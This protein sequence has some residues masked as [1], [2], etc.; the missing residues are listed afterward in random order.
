MLAPIERIH[1]GFVH[2]R[3]AR[4]LASQI[5]ALIEPH[6]SMLDIG[7]GDGVIGSLIADKT[8][9]E[10]TGVE[11]LIRR[12]AR[13]PLRQFDGRH[14]PFPDDSYD[15]A[16]LIDVLHHTA[17]PMVLLRE[18]T[19]VARTVVIKD[20]RRNGWLAQ[21]TLAFMDRV[22]NERFGVAVPA[23][24][25]SESEWLVAFASQPITVT[26]WTTDV[27][28]YPWPASLAFGRALHFV[29]RLSR[30]AD[31]SHRPAMPLNR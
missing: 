20:H 31:V 14:V 21:Q 23:N 2:G 7:A 6:A 9:S 30:P 17:D 24:Y 8:G 18:A 19:R 4:V 26:H 11:T 1:S 29:A 15:V 22:G 10:I 12:G 16:L 27:P 3:R 5:A 25:W 28:L 13:I